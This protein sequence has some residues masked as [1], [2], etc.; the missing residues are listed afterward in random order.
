VDVDKK[1]T[2]L[3]KLNKFIKNASDSGGDSEHIDAE[4]AHLKG[5]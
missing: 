3:Q 5:L 4:I 1:S 2:D